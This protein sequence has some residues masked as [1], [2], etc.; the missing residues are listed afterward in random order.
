MQTKV[1]LF[2]VTLVTFSIR[3]SSALTANLGLRGS[4]APLPP[5]G[6]FGKFITRI[7]ELHCNS[8]LYAHV[9]FTT[10]SSALRTLRRMLKQAQEWGLI[11]TAPKVQL[12]EEQGRDVLLEPWME[13][14]ER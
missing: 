10:F 9:A 8:T 1:I 13:A 4:N 11:H 5:G 6:Q 12:V 14:G 7:N 3:T 2:S